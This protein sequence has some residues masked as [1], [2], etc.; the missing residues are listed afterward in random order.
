MTR[1][2]RLRDRIALVKE[3][4]FLE[5]AR[6]VL[7]EL[8]L[9]L[10]KVRCPL[11]EHEDQGPSCSIRR[12]GWKCFGCQEGGDILDLVQG[13]HG[14]SLVEAIEYAEVELGLGGEDEDADLIRLRVLLRR[15]PETADPVRVLAGGLAEVTEE[16]LQQ[17]RP[18]LRCRDPWVYD[19]AWSRAGYVFSELDR[20]AMLRPKTVRRARAS[21]RDLRAWARAWAD[22]VEADVER[23]TG[24][25]ILDVATQ[26]RRSAFCDV[27]KQSENVL[28]KT[29]AGLLG[30]R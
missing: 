16:F 15:Q 10:G 30:S 4:P 6:L 22:D 19:L 1:R 14:L 8:D 24:K 2:R 27:A 25:D 28:R 11:P 20:E 7:P 18:Y 26:G 23:L 17:V 29:L 12:D 9:E 21:V 3:Q 5:V 13:Y